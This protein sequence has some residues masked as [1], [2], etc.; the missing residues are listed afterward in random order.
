MKALINR[1]KADYACGDLLKVNIELH[2]AV[3]P[4]PEPTKLVLRNGRKLCVE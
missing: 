3:A 4:G 2:V 1:V